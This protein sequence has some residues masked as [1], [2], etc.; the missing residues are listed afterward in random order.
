MTARLFALLLLLSS[1]SFANIVEDVR[2]AL[3]Q[4]NF[5]AADAELQ[6]YRIQQGATPEYLEA[7]SW[8]ARAALTTDQLD[9][10]EAYAKQTEML[11]LQQLQKRALD[12]EP[13]LP[14]ALGAALE[15]QAQVLSARGKDLQAVALLRRSL[16]AYR[17]T[18]IRAR[19]QKNLNLLS[20]VGQRAPALNITQHL[21]PKPAALSQVKGSPVLLFF[22]AHWCV[23]CKSEGP[24]ISR[25]RS[26]LAPK[27]LTVV[28]PTQ[29]YGYA[30]RGEDA[31][32]QTELA[33][34]ERVWQHFYPALQDVPVP[35]S[36]A[37]FNTY[38]ASTTPTLV[39]I[40]RAGRV[41]L[42]HPGVMPYDQ[43][44]AAIEKTLAN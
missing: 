22:W 12:A 41:A 33:Y 37:N 20:L 9:R 13:H 31:S 39:L 8:M 21:G 24:I 30:D 4:N 32:P 34:I 29:L 25:L 42:Y 23:D 19:L 27:G 6:S 16:A 14:I 44:R 43:L 18:S 38:G 40:D 26:E 10:A 15:V 3:A 1:L 17:N 7:L 11:A 28:A 5:T 2:S 36:K 35:V